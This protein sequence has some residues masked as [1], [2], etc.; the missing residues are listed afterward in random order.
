MDR[1]RIASKPLIVLNLDAI[2]DEGAMRDAMIA[3]QNHRPRAANAFTVLRDFDP[4]Y[5]GWLDAG[6]TEH[7]T[8]TRLP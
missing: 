7:G 8:P 4:I 3:A 2:D 1:E 6:V 5:Q